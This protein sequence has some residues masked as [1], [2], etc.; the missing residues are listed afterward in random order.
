MRIPRFTWLLIPLLLTGVYFHQRNPHLTRAQASPAQASGT[1]VVPAIAVPV[2]PLTADPM[3]RPHVLFSGLWRVDGNF[4][5]TIHIE[6]SL[7]VA[8]VEV[9]PVLYMADGAEYDLTPVI[10]P[11]A[12]TS[13]LSVNEA[14]AQAPPPIRAHLSSYGS[15]ALLYRGLAMSMAAKIEMLDAPRSQLFTASFMRSVMPGGMSKGA[16]QTLEGLVEARPG[17]GRLRQFCQQYGK[18][19]LG[20][21]SGNRF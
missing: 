1:P 5:S 4:E 15:A 10:V 13:M 7:V 19:G 14:L 21:L 8:P 20:E 18:D 17:S 2:V 12:G 11:T 16:M 9:T 3:K 6:N